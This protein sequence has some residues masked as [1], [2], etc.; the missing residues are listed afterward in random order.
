MPNSF[1][2][3]GRICLKLQQVISKISFYLTMKSEQNAKNSKVS[4]QVCIGNLPRIAFLGTL[5]ILK[6]YLEIALVDS[7][8]S[9]TPPADTSLSLTTTQGLGCSPV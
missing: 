6:C 7:E 1:D 2:M 5:C 9:I 4:M 8:K 3:D